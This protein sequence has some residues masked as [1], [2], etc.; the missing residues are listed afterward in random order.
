MKTIHR[1]GRLDLCCYSCPQK[2]TDCQ[3]F[4]VTD[5]LVT[6]KNEFFMFTCYK[7]SGK[8]VL[9]QPKKSGVA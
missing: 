7:R 6:I 8:M 2:V 4:N 5:S 9:F 1:K 3:F